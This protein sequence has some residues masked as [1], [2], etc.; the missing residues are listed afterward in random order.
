MGAYLFQVKD[1][2]HFPIRF[3]SKAFDERMS[4]WSTIQQEGY[5]IYYAITQWD[6]LLR[7]RQFHTSNRSRQPYH[8]KGG[9]ERQSCA[10]DARATSV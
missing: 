4:R 5:A 9:V 8:A 1:G 6:F 10:M 3:I 7:D 2:I